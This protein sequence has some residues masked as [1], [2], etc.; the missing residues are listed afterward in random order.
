MARLTEIGRAAPAASR[1]SGRPGPLA[2]L[3]S[4]D[5]GIRLATLIGILVV[6]EVI[7][8]IVRPIIFTS[9]QRAWDAMGKMVSDGSL[10]LA[11]EQTFVVLLSGLGLAAVFG[12]TLGILFGRYRTAGD[13]FEPEITAIFMTPRI[14]LLPIISLWLGF[15]DPAKVLIVFLFSFFEIYFTVRNGVRTVDRDF[16]EVARA[17]NVD[18]RTMLTKVVLPASLPYVITG[19]RLGLLHGMVGVVLVGFFLE[20]N[21]IGGLIFNY[22]QN[23]QIP[24]LFGALLTVMA[25]GMAI[26]VTLRWAERRIAPWR[27]G[28]NA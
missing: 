15:G 22:G 17:Y 21:G 9:P 26:N 18:E 13:L 3:A 16:V 6:W 12:V 4:R 5:N 27:A 11:W 8:R 25:V 20:N 14:A 1:R 23:F 2:R 10:L 24:F 7:S 28:A 19:L